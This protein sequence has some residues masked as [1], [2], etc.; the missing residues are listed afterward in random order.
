MNRNIKLRHVVIASAC[1]VSFS[2]DA[3]AD[4]SITTKPA[5][6][7]IVKSPSMGVMMRGHLVRIDSTYTGGVQTITVTV[8]P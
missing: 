7:I 3:G 6:N 5:A 8:A 1:A 2:A 4:Y